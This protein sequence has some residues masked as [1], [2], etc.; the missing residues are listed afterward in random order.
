MANDLAYGI[1]AVRLRRDQLRVEQELQ[2]AKDVAEAANRAKDHFLAVLSHELR[3]PLT[4]VLTTAQMLE[5]DPALSPEQRDAVSMI[6]RNAELEA[7]LIDDLL[8]LTKIARGKLELSVTIVGLHE[9]LRHVLA[10]CEND[11]TAK[12]L[13]LK[14]Q[15]EA[16]SRYVSADPT[17]L[18]QIL[19]N[20]LR[21]AVKFTPVGG[22]ISVR[23]HNPDDGHV[24]VAIQDTGAGIEPELLP[25]LFTAFEQGR[26]DVT[27]QFGGLG[28]GLAISKGLVDLH[29]GTLVAAS[30]G[31]GRGAT[32]T[33]TLRALSEARSKSPHALAHA[34]LQA[35][36][37]RR[38][39]L[40]VEDHA[41]TARVMSMLLKSHGCSVTLAGSVQEALQTLQTD[42]FDLLISDIGLPDGSGLDMMRQ[43]AA[44][45]PMKAI[46]LSG[47]GMEEDV[48]KSKEAGFVAHLT[49]PVDIQALVRMLREILGGSSS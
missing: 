13:N 36:G 42:A 25:R 22:S 17:R 41:D 35:L 23:T 34:P 46:A 31:Q 28:L 6:R 8:D 32:F 21:N 18:Q 47:Y 43:I 39:I 3:T 29:G 12:Q 30:E 11:I 48:R 16:K 24:V 2:Q 14:V 45:Q 49:K 7:R 4:P 20:L 10:M 38:R 9:R 19:W 44:T 37:A 40:L 26:K 5:M 15:M 1:T 27:R 33:L